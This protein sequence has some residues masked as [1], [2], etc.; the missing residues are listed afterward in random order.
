M[1]ALSLR[2]RVGARALLLLPLLASCAALRPIPLPK[3][4]ELHRAKTDDGWEISLTRYKA[5]GEIKGFPVVLCHGI[6]ANERNMDLDEQ[7]SMAR[8]I[9]SQGREAWTVSLRGTGT[10]DTIDAEHKR[11]GP[12]YFDDYW[13]HDLPAVIDYVKRTSGASAI[14]YAGHSMGGMVLYAYLSQGGQGVHAAATMGSPTRLDWGTGMESLLKTLGP[15][16]V[17]PES[18]IPSGVGA[19]LASPFQ[20]AME[21]GPFQRFFYNPQSTETETWR[22]LMVYGTAPVS[23][24]TALQ[25]I[26]LMDTGQFQTFD[27]KIDLR[28]DMAKITTPVLVVAGRLDRIAV[29]PAVKDGY[30]ALGGPK[31]WLLMTRANGS[32]GE[33]GHM[34][35]VIGERASTELWPKVLMFFDKA[36]PVAPL[37]SGPPEVL[38]SIPAAR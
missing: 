29:A 18:M 7:H 22:R 8:W 27:G 33:Y 10:S 24:G 4:A 2:E 13:R 14:D 12:I 36:T 6:S 9:A 25:L 37:P 3:E 23:G 19:L 15:V 20:G 11:P 26:S 1:S 34:D 35:M 17:S 5:V 30:R 31:E 28:A 38:P 32:R 16:F 21:D